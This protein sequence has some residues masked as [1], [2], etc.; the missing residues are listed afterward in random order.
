[1]FVF[2]VVASSWQTW[3][4]LNN[5]LVVHTGDENSPI[6]HDGKLEDYDGYATGV[7]HRNRVYEAKQARLAAERLAERMSGN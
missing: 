4:I 1:M 3:D 5:R 6:Y 7:C 2:L